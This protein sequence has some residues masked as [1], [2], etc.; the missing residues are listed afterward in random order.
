VTACPSRWVE[1][2]ASWLFYLESVAPVQLHAAAKLRSVRPAERNMSDPRAA[3]ARFYD[4][5][6]EPLADL[7]FYVAHLPSV[8]ARVLE[9]GAG[10]GRITLPLS[11]HCRFVHGIELSDAMLE[12]CRAK[13]RQS[14]ELADR[15]ILERRDITNFGLSATFDLIIAPYRVLQ[16]LETDH[17]V[18][19]MFRCIRNHVAPGGTCILN[20][21]NPRHSTAEAL[22]AAWS[23]P[24]ESLDWEQM[25]G[26]RVVTCH[27]R[28][29]KVREHPLVIYPELVYRV[30]E[31]TRQSEEVV[32]PLAM[33]CY[34]PDEFERLFLQH[35]FEIVERW[36]GYA[37]EP[38]GAGPELVIQARLAA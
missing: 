1:G 7:P 25:M 23:E 8:N 32:F 26:R 15:I 6:R 13:L 19:G 35:G 11:S 20:V 36:G 27:V 17:E 37:G 9:L 33:R 30:R 16:N 22:I 14:P 3:V 38:Y 5:D 4:L 2:M 12:I 18:A 29:G 34:F 28:K 31:G 24:V 10:T 21:F